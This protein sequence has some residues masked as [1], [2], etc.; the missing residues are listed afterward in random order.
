MTVAQLLQDVEVLEST[1]A[2]TLDIASL[3]YDSRK[4]APGAAFVAVCGFAVDGHDYLDDALARG[5]SLLVVQKKPARQDV[6]YVLVADTRRALAQ[7]SNNFFMRPAE[8]M[9]LIGVTGTN[10]KTTV[11]NLI[12]TVLAYQGALC[13]LIG[14]NENRIGTLRLPA[15]R[16]TPE[17]YELYELLAQMKKSGCS[18]AIL[19]VSSH[20]LALDRVWGLHFDVAVFTNFSQDHLDFHADMEDYFL[21]KAKLFTRCSH[22]VLNYDDP[23]GQRLLAQSKAQTLTYSADDNNA[24]L[25]AKN[26]QL[27]VSGVS[28]EAV[29]RG[30]I[31]RMS[32][33]IPGR[34]SVYNTLATVGCCTCLG[35]DMATIAAALRTA[36]GVK[37]RAEVV[38][39]DTDYTVII[40]YAHS[41]DSMENILRTVR[42]FAK[43]RIIAVFGCGGDRDKAKR[44]LM[45]KV[46]AQGADWCI[47][48]SDNPR[49][50]Q[51]QAIIDEILVG[52]QGFEKQTE[53]IV[54]RRAA[55][56][57]A[58]RSARADDVVVLMGKGHETYQE[59]DG[60]KHHFDEREEVAKLLEQGE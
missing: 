17:S 12:R 23:A 52:M 44:P 31:Q 45:G 36:Q 58:L 29:T 7:M 54:D 26:V 48:T 4:V 32:L 38:P 22:A 28:F 41:P 34:F 39:T 13:G 6:P 53:V 40:D 55:I 20:S 5:A 33:G 60:Q 8:G 37:G 56:A 51:P 1:C 9:K 15:V 46:G 43:G 2:Q 25:V 59:I 14:T 16:T 50:E 18:H 42:G 27:K 57:H 19:E 21:A 11:T 47:V 24:D 35:L 30:S 49:S 3:C 10:G